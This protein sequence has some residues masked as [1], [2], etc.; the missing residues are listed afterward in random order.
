MN[1]LP[2]DILNII[3]KMR[4]NLL[5]IN[6]CQEINN[7]IHFQCLHFSSIDNIRN[8]SHMF[9]VYYTEDPKLK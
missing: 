6:L 5:M 9:F 3:G 2:T 1:R 4:H 7:I 8:I